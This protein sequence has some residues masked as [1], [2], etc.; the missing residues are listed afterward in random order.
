MNAG[1]STK[2]T[3]V[4]SRQEVCNALELEMPASIRDNAEVIYFASAT[5]INLLLQIN[6]VF[7]TVIESICA[8]NNPAPDK[9]VSVATIILGAWDGSAKQQVT[10]AELMDSCYQLNPNFIKG[11]NQILPKSINRILSE[12]PDLVF[13]NEGGYL[14][15]NYGVTDSGTLAFPVGSADF[16]EWE[17]TLA[18]AADEITTFEQLEPHLS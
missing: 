12:I 14:V 3:M 16:M 18:N 13:R 2:C 9:L 8:L 4:V 6:P 5:S 17:N 10:I 11:I 1:I 15:W 7:R